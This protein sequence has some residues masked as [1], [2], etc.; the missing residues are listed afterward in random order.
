VT[1][2]AG[3]H[4]SAS[5]STPLRDRAGVERDLHRI[6]PELLGIPIQTEAS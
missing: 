5:S 4:T 2:T 3:A 6:E 1:L